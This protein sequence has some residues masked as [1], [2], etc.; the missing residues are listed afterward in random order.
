MI[1]LGVGALAL[2]MGHCQADLPEWGGVSWEK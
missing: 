2:Q 1:Y